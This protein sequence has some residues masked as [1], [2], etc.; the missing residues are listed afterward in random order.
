MVE[1]SVTEV[2]KVEQRVISSKHRT[3]VII[4]SRPNISEF[5]VS[6]CLGQMRLSRELLSVHAQAKFGEFDE[7][8]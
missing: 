8:I 6:G 2:S 3:E 7:E 1:L 5:V 4:L